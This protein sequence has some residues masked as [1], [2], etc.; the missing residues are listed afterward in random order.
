MP[1]PT[2]THVDGKKHIHIGGRKSALAVRQS[3]IVRAYIEQAHPATTCSILALSTLGDKVQLKPLYLFGG[4]ALW[5]KELETLLLE[6]V[7]SYPQLDMIVHLL[8]DMPTNL[9]DE[10]ALGCILDRQDPRDALVMKKD[11]PYRLLAELPRGAVVGTSS[12]RRLAQ[13]LRN[14]PDLQFVDVRGNIATRLSKLDAPDL[15]YHCLVLAAAGLMRTGMDHRITARLE[16]PDMYYA[17]GQGALGVEI[18]KDDA[19]MA[20]VLRRIEHVP[21]TLRCLAERAMMRALEGGC[22]VPLGVHTSYDEDTQ[23]L[24]FRGI[25]VSP[26]GLECVEA[27]A[28][29]KVLTYSEAEALGEEVA[30][31]LAA[32][33]GKDILSAINF[34]KINQRPVEQ[35]I[36]V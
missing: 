29:R 33:G 15:P 24:E 7:D 26:D 16:P 2:M 13:L 34:D 23:M 17:V 6:P 9:P 5:T 12:I 30:A 14:Y 10:F 22:L 3:E 35:E 18:R 20:A 1:H 11:S 21:S 36:R 25:I 28:E 8:K 27:S 31:Q 19:A 32:Q 4:K